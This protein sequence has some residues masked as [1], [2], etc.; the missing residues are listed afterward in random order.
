MPWAIIVEP[1]R[2]KEL[3]GMYKFNRPYGT[4]RDFL[5]PVPSDES[6]G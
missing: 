3:A 4:D 2:L 5:I 1:F 6:L